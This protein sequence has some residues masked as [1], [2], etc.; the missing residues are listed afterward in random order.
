MKFYSIL[1]IM[2]IGAYYGCKIAIDDCKFC[3]LKEKIFA[4]YLGLC[5]GATWPV[6]IPIWMYL[7]DY[8]LVIR[9]KEKQ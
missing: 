6:S 7:D 4:S 1:F 8:E 5:I 2:L 9:K 3:D